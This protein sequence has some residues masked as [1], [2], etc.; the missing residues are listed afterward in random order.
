MP[1]D[2]RAKL[3]WTLAELSAET[4][5]PPRT[6]RYY[7]ARGLLAGPVVAGRGAEYTQDHFSRLGQVRDLQARGLTLAEISGVLSGGG[8][9]EEL[10]QPEKWEQYRLSEDVIVSIRSE[11][12][13]W[14]L[15]QLKESL[16]EF[17]R[18]IGGS[19]DAGDND[20][21]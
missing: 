19:L 8:E 16:L 1:N 12:A 2:S 9:R 6:I 17:A 18:R 14:R 11:A 10:P 4:G 5:V 3:A 21:A 7:I 13:P 20:G 15:K